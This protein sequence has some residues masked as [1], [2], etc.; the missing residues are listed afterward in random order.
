[1]LYPLSYG[2]SFS[3]HITSVKPLSA[4]STSLSNHTSSMQRTLSTLP[5]IASSNQKKP[6][7][8]KLEKTGKVLIPQTSCQAR[9]GIKQPSKS[10][11]QHRC[12]QPYSNR[13]SDLLCCTLLVCFILFTGE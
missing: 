9:R 2:R 10:H 8:F 13:L 3:H 11:R 12:S 5:Q 4:L 7:L 1:M 6:M